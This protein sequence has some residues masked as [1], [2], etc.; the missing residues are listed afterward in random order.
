MAALDW[1]Y[2][3]GPLVYRIYEP[4]TR[5]LLYVG[6]TGGRLQERMRNHQ[7]KQD[8]FYWYWAR[9]IVT[10]QEYSS[11]MP[12][13]AAE[14]WAIEALNPRYN[15]DRPDWRRLADWARQRPDMVVNGRHAAWYYQKGQ[16]A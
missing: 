12:A 16:F 10:Y 4:Y 3:V 1:Q 8:W 5:E 6:Q 2:A 9:S 14:A 13:L 15:K 7:R 11:P